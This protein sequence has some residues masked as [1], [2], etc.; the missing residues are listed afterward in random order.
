MARRGK[1][2]VTRAAWAAGVAS[3]NWAD[4]CKL[5]RRGG[6]AALQGPNREKRILFLREQCGNVYENKGPAWKEWA[7]SGNVYE[8]KGSYVFKAGMYLKTRQLML[9]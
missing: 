9:C 1:L 7:E 6:S 8:N 5:S 3:G 4:T 2:S